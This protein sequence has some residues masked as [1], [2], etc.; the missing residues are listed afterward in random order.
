MS[1]ATCKSQKDLAMIA[2]DNAQ[3]D[4]CNTAALSAA[5]QQA[6]AAG[7]WKFRIKECQN[8][9][10]RERRKEEARGKLQSALQTREAGDLE[11]AIEHGISTCVAEHEL[12]DARRALASV[13]IW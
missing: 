2:L 8:L 7:V 10:D 6:E 13:R 3:K 1:S 12:L 4:P 5:I 11:E 9:I